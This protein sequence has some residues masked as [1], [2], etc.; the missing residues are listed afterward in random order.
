MLSGVAE[1]IEEN[2]TFMPSVFIFLELST[3]WSASTKLGLLTNTSILIGILSIKV[4]KR[5]LFLMFYGF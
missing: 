3:A 1:T 4:N 5:L 2:L